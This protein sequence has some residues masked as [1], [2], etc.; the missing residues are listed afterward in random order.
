MQFIKDTLT[1]KIYATRE[2]MGKNAAEE[3]ALRIKELLSQKDEVNMIFA[4][5]PSQNE[6]LLSLCS[7]K[8]IEWERVNA[9]HMDEY[10][11]LP[12]GAPQRFSSFLYEHIFSLL[13]FKSVNTLNP[14][15]TTPIR[16]VRDIQAFSEIILP[17]SSVWV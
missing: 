14:P 1:V 6:M 9:F 5:A 3:C 16:N 13:P 10:V 8:G 4:A 15:T 11:G 17:T 7:Q 2:E 12:E